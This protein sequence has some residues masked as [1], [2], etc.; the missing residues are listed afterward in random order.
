MNVSVVAPAVPRWVAR[1]VAPVAAV[2]ALVMVP[3]SV[4]LGF[5]L[6]ATAQARHWNVAW[7]G[8]DL[9]LALGLAAT[10][11]W[12]FR[13]DRRAA[14]AATVTGT[15]ALVDAWFDVCTAEAGGPLLLAVAM[16][17][18]GELPLAAACLWL[19]RTVARARPAAS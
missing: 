15:L 16:A 9:A 12:G 14:T 10:A 11:W 2:I 18:L 1:R 8:L 7:V 4:G 5:T 6:P 3:W 19:A 13:R 17:V